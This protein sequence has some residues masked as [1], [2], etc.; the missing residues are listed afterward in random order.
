MNLYIHI[1]S[2]GVNTRG[3]V[4]PLTEAI[5][6]SPLHKHIDGCFAQVNAGYSNREDLFLKD[7]DVILDR[8]PGY[9]ESNESRIELEFEGTQ[10]TFPGF[11]KLA[12]DVLTRDF[13][14]ELKGMF[15]NY[16]PHKSRGLQF[17]AG[18]RRFT[19]E[20]LWFV[21]RCL[22]TMQKICYETFG[23]S[24]P[25]SIWN[26]PGRDRPEVNWDAVEESAKYW[27]LDFKFINEYRQHS[28][29]SENY[30]SIQDNA[31]AFQS[32]GLERIAAI[33]PRDLGTPGTFSKD[34][35]MALAAKLMSLRYNGIEGIFYW[36]NADYI[37]D[38]DGEIVQ[39]K[40]ETVMGHVNALGRML[41]LVR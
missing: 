29:L 4:A 8:V 36:M 39:E 5:A 33:T 17:D 25:K 37:G 24:L 6:E 20:E 27:G 35:E 13:P 16:E 14:Y 19:T 26:T 32:V 41:D 9:C 31:K 3:L 1:G 40:F 7:A 38:T 18:H 34:D 28:T 22:A 12:R 11:A 21:H 15:L 23:R 2:G 10:Y 30:Q